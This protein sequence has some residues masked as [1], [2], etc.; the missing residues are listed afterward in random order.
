LKKAI[1]LFLLLSFVLLPAYAKNA[2][3]YKAKMYSEFN[4]VDNNTNVIEFSSKNNLKISR[5]VDIPPNAKIKAQIIESQKERRWHKSGFL[6][7]KL[8]NFTLEGITVDISKYDAYLIARKY[9]PI[10][11]KEAAI[12]ATELIVMSG[13]AFF[14]PGVDIGYFFAKGAILRKK[15]KNWFKAGVKN[16][17]DNSI[18]W[19]WLKGKPI[20]LEKNDEIKLKY[21]ETEEARDLSAKVTYRKDKI[22][23]KKEKKIVKREIKEIKREIKQEKVELA[24]YDKQYKK[25][26]KQHKKMAL[27]MK[28]EVER[29][30]KIASK[31]KN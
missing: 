17:Y 13:A 8:L 27:I 15:D 14:A 25:M 21:V 9:E 2:V 6:V 10:D 7:C 12:L 30:A 28:K 5:E 22:K 29:R 1:S 11:K 23:F 26:I 3:N 24:Y 31:V 16:A 4:I 19:F 18:C 20:N